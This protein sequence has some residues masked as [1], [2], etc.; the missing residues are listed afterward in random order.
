MY[1]VNISIDD[2]SPHP[3]SST[4]VLDV[5]W[6]LIDVFKEI[7]FTLFVPIAYR[8][9]GEEEYCIDK[10][11]DFID[12]IRELPKS[13]FEIGWHGYHHDIWNT[14]H[15]CK[16]REFRCLNYEE[17]RMVFEKMFEVAT[18]AGLVDLFI[19]IFRPPAFKLSLSAIEYCKNIGIGIST[20]INVNPPFK[21]LKLYEKTSI[22][23]HACEWD[24]SYFSKERAEE[25]K[26]FLNDNLD[27][28]E[29]VFMG[30]MYNIS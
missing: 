20:K 15:N 9:I 29:F 21:C 26:V 18:K 4:K 3:K 11:K 10:F 6:K 28:I 7:K 8:L 13:N 24:K 30:N 14:E 5:C 16:D 27:E 22:L 23:Y 2:V 1:R 17:T 19:P 25:L 12:T